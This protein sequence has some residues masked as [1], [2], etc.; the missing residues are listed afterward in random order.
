[1]RVAGHL[2][3]ISLAGILAAGLG[4]SALAAP[5]RADSSEQFAPAEAAA[6]SCMRA[7]AGPSMTTGEETLGA[8]HDLSDACVA[9]PALSAADGSGG[10]PNAAPASKTAPEGE[11]SATET[12]T[13]FD[14][15]GAVLVGV[16]EF[17]M[18]ILASVLAAIGGAFGAALPIGAPAEMVAVL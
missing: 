11:V 1:M 13:V 14:L 15:I 7:P 17:V 9:Q 8:H 16:L 5:D 18:S 4:A 6:A 3:Q 12:R 2:R 10:A